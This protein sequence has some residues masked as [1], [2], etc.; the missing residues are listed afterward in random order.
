[1]KF[2]PFA[3]VALFAVLALAPASVAQTGRAWFE[4]APTPI[5]YEISVTPDIEAGTFAGETTIVIESD[6]TRANIV[7]NALDI[8]VTRATI[9]NRAVAFAVD[10]DAQTLT[11]T[12]RRPLRAGRHTIRIT[13]SG[14]IFDDAYGLFRVEYDQDGETRRALATQFQVGDARRFSPMWDQPNMRSVFSISVTARSDLMAIG[15]M[16]VARTQSVAGGLTRTTFQDTPSMASYLLFLGVGD[17]E[18]V[19]TDVDGVELG[20]VV[21][22]GQ[23]ERARYALQAGVQS[24]RYFEE[25]FGIEYPLP[26]LDMVGVPGAGGFAAMENWGAILYFDQYILVD[27]NATSEAERRFVFEV[28]AH[29]IAHQWFGNLVTM[30]WWNDLWLNEGFASWAAGKAMD[31][32]HPEWEPWLSQRAG[33]TEGA[34]GQD[35]RIGT[36]PVVQTVNTIDDANAAFDAIS[37]EKGLAVIRMMEAYVGED[38]F[39][40]GVHDYLS[41]RLYGNSVTDDLWG[42]IQ[43]ASGQPVLEIARSF[44]LQPGYP[45]L[46]TGACELSAPG[47][48]GQDNLV[49]LRQRRFALD[50]ASRTGE[51][52][53][54][55]VVVRSVGGA[56]FRSVIGPGENNQLAL[57]CSAYLLNGGQTGFFRVH[58]DQGNF[59]RLVAS[60]AQ[61]DDDDQLGLMLDYW[62]FSR[63]GDAP[64]T[65]YLELVN[66]LPADADPV[67]VMDAAQS[68]AAIAGYARGRESEAAVRAYGLRVLQ[69]YFARWGW[70]PRDDEEPNVRLARAT[71][72]STLGGLGD[73]SVLA[74]ARRRVAAADAGDATAL[75]GTVRSAALGLLA[76]SA[77]EAEYDAM[78]ARARAT[79]DFVEQRRLWRLLA[80]SGDEALARRTLALTLGEDIPRQI[81]PQIV[82]TVAG[83]HPRLAWD[84]L[85]ANRATVESLLDPLQRL[86]YAASIAGASSEPAIADALAEYGR[87][88]P[89]AADTIAATASS[90][91]LRAGLAERTMPAVEAWIA[92]HTPRAGRGR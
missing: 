15:N 63:S 26:K 66:A 7:M 3:V 56:E 1:M 34:M 12:P 4:N 43:A 82:Q 21:R 86:D 25:Y 24:L 80:S 74:E 22:R 8:E 81:R 90:I 52:W 77:T 9:N 38:A 19:T 11:L 37:Y 73:E 18:R 83:A 23:T 46:E 57:P 31:A 48:H 91:R 45:V 33:G 51:R 92:R 54:I 6:E 84:F 55:P 41:A 59:T 20:I 50:E 53:S 47:V 87:D 5:R 69:P 67:V 35:A 2:R 40:R 13:Y 58:Y 72:I 29:E 70:D 88:M 49:P 44:T 14:R 75:H 17:F 30:T 62:A 42:A 32:L 28:V 64:L 61:L 79:S 89:S 71:L 36:H 85:V 78:L 39:R 60:F 76:V 16:P 27:E 68:L 10:N 65:D